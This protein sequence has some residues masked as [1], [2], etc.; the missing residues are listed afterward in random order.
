MFALFFLACEP[1]SSDATGFEGGNF[2]F[3]TIG[4]SDQ[5]YDGAFETIFMPEGTPEDFET[6]I[7]LPSY[8]DLPAT[9]NIDIQD[10]FGSMEVTV[11]AGAQDGTM[12]VL[13]AAQTGVELD[14]DQWPDC[15]VDADIDIYLTITGDNEVE[16]NAVLHTGSFDEASCPV[17]TNDPCDIKLDITASRI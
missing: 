15:L 16:G 5:C 9:Y 7:E 14:G 12:E 2:Q 3:T 8:A 1:T 11:D 6:P 17:V 13:G 10:P 4:V